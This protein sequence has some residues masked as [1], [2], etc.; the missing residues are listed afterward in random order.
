MTSAVEFE[1]RLTTG[2]KVDMS[3]LVATKMPVTGVAAE[4]VSIGPRLAPALL[5][6]SNDNAL[7]AGNEVFQHAYAGAR[8]AVRN[9]VPILVAL[10]TEIVLHHQGERQ[11]SAFSR[12]AF[13]HAKATAH[14]AVALFA[15]TCTETS[16]SER[17][18]GVTR[19]LSHIAAALDVRQGSPQEPADLEIEALLDHCRCFAQAASEQP[20]S[21]RIRAEF[22]RDAGPRILH[23]TELA[24]CEQIAGLHRAVEATLEPLSAGDRAQL[25]V[26]VV[27]DHQARA[28]SLGMQYFKRRFRETPGADERITYGE[29]IGNEEEAISLVATRRLDKRIALAFFGDE[30]RLQR[31]VLGDAA[32]R[33]LD[34]MCW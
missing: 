10:P 29:H 6:S 12:P 4:R 25:Q 32:K 26:V 11:V 17:R 18:T 33:C 7:E 34:E 1:P 23:I 9:Q 3:R 16:A 30:N 5:M 22:A 14:I 28:R 8:E 27:G 15:L 24:T 20:L 13:E 19:L 21:A 31:D 2:M